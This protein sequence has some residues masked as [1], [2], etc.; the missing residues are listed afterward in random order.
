MQCLLAWWFAYD[1]ILTLHHTRVKFWLHHQQSVVLHS[2]LNVS[3]FPGTTV[4]SARQT[5]VLVVSVSSRAAAARL[6]L[7]LMLPL[8]PILKTCAPARPSQG[9]LPGHIIRFP[10]SEFETFVVSSP[11]RVGF[12]NWL[13]TF[14]GRHYAFSHSSFQHL[15]HFLGR[16]L[17]NICWINYEVKLKVAHSCPTLCD[18][19]DYIQSMEF[20]RPEYW[21]G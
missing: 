5:N 9:L 11:S 13:W 17:T 1:K 2:L 14:R 15:A 12:P 19:M 18:P 8:H 6:T 16:H 7:H 10:I 21:S 4:P 20:S 3:V